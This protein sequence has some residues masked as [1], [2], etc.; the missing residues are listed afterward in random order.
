MGLREKSNSWS[1]FF[2]RLRVAPSTIEGEICS[3]L[4]QECALATMTEVFLGH[5][6]ATLEKFKGPERERQGVVTFVESTKADI[7]EME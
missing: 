1:I 3:S 4:T 6:I 7:V 5:L 2:V